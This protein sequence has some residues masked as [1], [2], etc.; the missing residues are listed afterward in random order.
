MGLFDSILG[1]MAGGAG[2]SSSGGT[3]MS[4]INGLL[5]QNGGIQGLANQFSQ[6]GHGDT[7]NSWVS[8]GQNMPISGDQV[9]RVLG[10]EQM[11]GLAAK[12][13]VDPAQVSHF[14]AEYLPKI[15]DGMTPNGTVGTAA[16]QQQSLVALLPSLMQNISK[17]MG[18]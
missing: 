13:G 7:F 12:L 11:N 3:V 8:T 15:I 5:A 10:S 6:Y 1:A 9:Q 14:L 2:G 18:A 17:S 4:L 16:N